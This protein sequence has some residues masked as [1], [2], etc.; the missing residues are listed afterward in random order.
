MRYTAQGWLKKNE[1]IAIVESLAMMAYNPSIGR[2]LKAGGVTKFKKIVVRNIKGLK[3]IKNQRQFDSFLDKFVKE[4][5]KR[6][7][8]TSVGNRISYGQGQKAVNVFLKVYVD[9][10]SYPDKKTMDRI[11]RFL[12]VPFLLDVIWARAPR[13]RGDIE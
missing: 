11:K 13:F 3:K 12:H 5:I 9:W 7:K 4:V 6:I 2:V 10:A 8:I 1:Q